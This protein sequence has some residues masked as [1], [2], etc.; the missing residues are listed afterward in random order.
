MKATPNILHSFRLLEPSKAMYLDAMARSQGSSESDS[1][2]LRRRESVSSVDTSKQLP[3]VLSI[4]TGY[5]GIER[6]LT[7]AGFEHRTIAVLEIEAYAIANLL[8][9]ME[10]G[11]MVPAPVWTDLKTLPVDCFRDRVDLLVG[12]YPCQGF[13]T[14]GL[15]KGSEDPRYLW[16]YIRGHIESI[17]PVRCFFENVEGHISLGLREVI[18]DLESLGYKTKWGI[19]S[20]SECGA[21]HQRK[22]VF[23]LADS[24]STR[25]QTQR[26]QSISQ[27]VTRVASKSSSMAHAISVPRRRGTIHLRS[28][29]ERWQASDVRGKSLQQRDGDTLPDHAKQSSETLAYSKSKRVQGRGAT[30]Q[31]EPQSHAGKKISQRHSAASGADNWITEPN[32]GRVANGSAFRVDRLRLLGNGVVPQ[33]AAKAWIILNE[34]MDSEG[35][36]EHSK[37]HG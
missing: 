28:D 25:F 9:K 6:G 16:G 20:A 35:T 22:R 1:H 17:R 15:R 11:Q 19:F 8:A 10:T 24:S 33:Q 37:S 4:C 34:Q 27:R 2:K 12:G 5:G 32:V 30:Q 21:P 26:H 36:T 18:E 31:Q 29:N 23:I 3:T 7:L 13:S 14:S